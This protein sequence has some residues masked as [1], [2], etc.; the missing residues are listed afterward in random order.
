MASIGTCPSSKVYLNENPVAILRC[1]ITLSWLRVPMNMRKR[2]TPS[3][4]DYLVVLVLQ[5]VHYVAFHNF[6]TGPGGVF[7]DTLQGCPRSNA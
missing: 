7:Y 1:G 4:F 6:R 2:D 5:L 3:F